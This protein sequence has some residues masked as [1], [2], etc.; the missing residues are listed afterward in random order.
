MLFIECEGLGL[1]AVVLDEDDLEGTIARLLENGA[2]AIIEH[3]GVVFRRNDDAH[4]LLRIRRLVDDPVVG[5]V[6][7]DVRAY[8][9]S[10]HVL[11]KQSQITLERAQIAFLVTSMT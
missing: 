7:C 5:I 3:G 9:P 6:S 2:D 10:M 1:R 8:V 11:R 4:E